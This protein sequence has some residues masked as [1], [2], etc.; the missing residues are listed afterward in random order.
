MRT[1]LL[2]LAAIAVAAVVV[3]AVTAQPRETP[4]PADD[5]QRF[6]VQITDEMRRHS[7]LR[8]TLY[9][10]GTAYGIAVPLILLASGFSRRMRDRAQ[11]IAKKPFLTAMLY[12][13]L[14]IVA[15]EILSF[16]LAYYSG[17]IV[18]HQ[19]E[20]TKQTFGAWMGEN[21]KGLIVSI[22]LSAPVGAL[23]LLAMRR[24]K[25]WWLPLW[26]GAVPLV[27]LL[28]V[29][30]PV[31]LEPIFNKF[32]PVKDTVLRQKLLDLASRAGIEGGRVYQVDKSK[33]TT[34]LNAYVNGIG[35][36]KR[37]V[38]WDTIIA[39]MTH[40]ELLGV[41]GHEMGHYV[42]HHMWKGLGLSLVGMLISFFL[43][44]AAFDRVSA[45]RK[46]RW[47]ITEAGD[48]AAIP[49]LML[50]GFVITFA[51]TPIG[52][53]YSRHQE[54]NADIFALELT[55]KNEAFATA[56]RKLA[57]ESK[58]T[59]AP[60]PIIKYWR[61]THP[62]I[63]ERIPFALSYRPWEKGQP[64]QMWTGTKGSGPSAQGSGPAVS[65]QGSPGAAP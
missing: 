47:G 35:P 20:L 31:L 34:T 53:A 24:F 17:F 21:L 30:Q 8:D 1:F 51:A 27:L 43:T 6:E 38:M 45:E 50:I 23:A 5:D 2:G 42:M 61:Y 19:F 33:Q 4:K 11:Q 55:R 54:H 9:F 41:M 65:R 57:E 40:D 52:A 48:P 39:K 62:P 60:H 29:V 44:Q 46:R 59:P 10:V 26:L 16:P 25:R 32:E 63:A 13:A 49:L 36:T 14:F 37:I 15:T 64:N 3:V 56:F 22:A 7:R 12:I 58:R 28:V 18:P